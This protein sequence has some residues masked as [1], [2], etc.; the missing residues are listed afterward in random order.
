MCDAELTHETAKVHL[1]FSGDDIDPPPDAASVGSRSV[2]WMR[3][4]GNRIAQLFWSDAQGRYEIETHKFYYEVDDIVFGNGRFALG[5][6]I[7]P[8]FDLKYG[9]D[10]TRSVAEC[11]TGELIRSNTLPAIR[12]RELYFNEVASRPRFLLMEEHG[13]FCQ[14]SKDGLQIWDF[15]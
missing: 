9:P 12:S 6:A 11:L 1:S 5:M 4:P 15:S 10:D 13:T 7:C 8:F 14:I 2:G 3:V